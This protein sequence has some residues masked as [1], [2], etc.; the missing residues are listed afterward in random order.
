MKYLLGFMFLLVGVVHGQAIKPDSSFTIAEIRIGYGANYF[1][2]G[3][4]EAYNAGNFSASGG[5]LATLAAYHKFRKIDHLVFG[6]KFKSLGAAPSKG[7]NGHEM[8]FNYWGAALTTR[9]YPFSK[10][11][12]EGFFAQADYFFVTQFTQK[13][14]STANLV[15]D[16]QFAIGNGYALGIGYQ[17]AMPNRRNALTLGV[18]YEVDRRTGEV[19]G[20]GSKTFS[21][22]SLGV[23][24]G[25]VF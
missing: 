12:R 14:R 11:A 23:L 16:H 20:V 19:N 7:D 2:S 4:S 6:M 3:L 24:F 13:Y 5:V 1:G 25:F 22:S 9:Y 15:F 10:N 17:F 21:S 8:F 18:E